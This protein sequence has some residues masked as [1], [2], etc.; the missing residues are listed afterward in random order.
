[1]S[2]KKQFK[3]T[4]KASVIVPCF[5]ERL[6]I[7]QCID[8]LLQ[9][10]YD[11][12]E[13]IVINDGST[14][15]TLNILSSYDTIKIINIERSG[16]LR[17]IRAGIDNASGEIIL[18]TDADSIVPCDWI[19][20][21]V[22][23][24]DCPD[25]LIAGGT[26]KNIH[27]KGGLATGLKYMDEIYHNFL[28]RKLS[29]CRITGSNWATHRYLLTNKELYK[30]IVT[31]ESLLLNIIRTYKGKVIF[32]KLIYVT[33]N[34]P[35][36]VA[37]IWY[38]KYLWG[39]RAVIDRMYKN[40]VFWVRPLYFLLGIISFC[41]ICLPIGKILFTIFGLPLIGLM[42]FSSK[43]IFFLFTPL[44]FLISEFGYVCGSAT[45]FTEKLIKKQ[46]WK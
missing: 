39:R 22:K 1:M 29:V 37:G 11:D 4:M 21:L 31:D 15:D 24:F 17:A 46:L 36:N 41:L 3:Q 40:K 23:H 20:R 5:N 2:V 26:F 38:R 42:I 14:D 34:S 28:K 30:N 45:S 25:I 7:K 6:H 19:A 8:S 16:L 9:N 43:S 27:G 13:I 18:K 35:H 33:I 10:I 32:D 12:K 44:V